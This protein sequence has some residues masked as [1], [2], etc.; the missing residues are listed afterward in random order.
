MANKQYEVSTKK[1]TYQ[2]VEEKVLIEWGVCRRDFCGRGESLRYNPRPCL[3]LPCIATCRGRM[4][5]DKMGGDV[6][7]GKRLRYWQ[8]WVCKRLARTAHTEEIND[9]VVLE[10]ARALC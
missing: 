8:C 5:Q 4:H 1:A 10:L 2:P 9:L 6:G 7:S 3:H